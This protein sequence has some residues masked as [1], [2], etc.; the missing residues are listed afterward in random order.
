M[1]FVQQFIN[2]LAGA[3]HRE[4]P[5]A[6]VSNGSWNFRASTDVSGFHNY[7]R[8]DRLI[9]AGGDPDGTL[10]FIQVHY[11]PQWEQNETSPFHNKASHWGIAK[12]IV[13]GEFPANGITDDVLAPGNP[14][15]SPLR[16]VEES[17]EYAYLHGYAGV[18]GWSWSDTQFG[19]FAEAKKGISYLADNY[20]HG[21]VA[22]DTLW[23]GDEGEFLITGL[24]D[25]EKDQ[26]VLFPNPVKDNYLNIQLNNPT[27]FSYEI[28][29]LNGRTLL[30]GDIK[31]T[32]DYLIHLTNLRKGVYYLRLYNSQKSVIRKFI[33]G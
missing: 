30:L 24:E 32:R 29:D 16:T 21:L 33:K 3:I 31:S 25:E 20:W 17:Y 27:H 14:G 15:P 9:D 28:M 8:D 19:G 18:M 23:D 10:D 6:L 26:P 22:H 12:P 7:Y 2:L 11:Y 1:H 13:I 5:T 4:V